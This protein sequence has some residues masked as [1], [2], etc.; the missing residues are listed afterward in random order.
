METNLLVELVKKGFVGTSDCVCLTTPICHTPLSQRWP[1]ESMPFAESGMVPD[2]IFNP[3]GF[4]S[5]M[6]I[7]ESTDVAH[8]HR[9]PFNNMTLASKH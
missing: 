2:I 6:T 7:G 5:R 8:F 9:T 4:P 3:H 1:S